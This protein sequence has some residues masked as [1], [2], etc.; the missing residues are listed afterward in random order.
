M[1]M[2]STLYS[3]SNSNS[4]SNLGLR[5]HLETVRPPDFAA[6]LIALFSDILTLRRFFNDPK[7]LEQ[8]CQKFVPQSLA[9]RAMCPIMC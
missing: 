8:S 5:P 4:H 7:L 1:K 6:T 9:Y 3:N 2:A